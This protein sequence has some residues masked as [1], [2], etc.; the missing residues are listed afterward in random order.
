MIVEDKFFIGFNSCNKQLLFS[1]QAALNVFLDVA[2]LHGNLAGENITKVSTRWLLTSYHVKFF[3]RPEYGEYIYVRTWGKTIKG[4]LSCREFEILDE[5]R[6]VLCIA[7][8]N[9]AHVDAYKRVLV[10]TTQELI[11]GYQCEENRTNFGDTHNDRLFLPS[12][13][14]YIKSCVIDRDKLDANGHMN[15]VKYLALADT[16][17]PNDI[18]TGQESNEFVI[19]YKKELFCDDNVDLYYYE[20][21]DE[22]YVVMKNGETTNAIIKY[23]K[24]K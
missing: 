20:N 6:N 23:L 17:L 4:V 3:K 5:N 11:D 12:E 16:V 8:S 2:S 24:N 22:Y 9:W 18:Y 1:N 14:Q 10:R 19:N 21:D 13:M 7:T 15:N